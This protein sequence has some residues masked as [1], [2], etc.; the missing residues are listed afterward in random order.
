MEREITINYREI[1]K[2]YYLERPKVRQSIEELRGELDSDWVKGRR[3]EYIGD[4]IKRLNCHIAGCEENYSDS[5]KQ[6]VPYWLRKITLD[7]SGYKESKK[8]LKKLLA[9]QRAKTSN[10]EIKGKIT[11]EDIQRAKEYPFENLIEVNRNFGICPYHEDKHPSFFVKNNWGHCFTCNKSV[12]TI[13]FVMDMQ[14]LTFIE[15]V[16]FLTQ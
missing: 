10:K 8:E 5:F 7:L 2:A 4:I 16:R 13:Q 14:N 6:N 1:E 12:D 3:L 11:E 15:A 9:E